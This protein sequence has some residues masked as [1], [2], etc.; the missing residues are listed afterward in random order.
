MVDMPTTALYA[1][2]EPLLDDRRLRELVRSWRISSGERLKARRKELRM[3][4]AHL[5]ELVDVRPTAISKFELGIATPKDSIRLA[6]ACSLMCEVTDIWPVI[7][8]AQ[9]MLVARRLAA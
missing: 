4:Q 9:T 6:I 8:R 3:S 2:P 1:E 7:D 5:A